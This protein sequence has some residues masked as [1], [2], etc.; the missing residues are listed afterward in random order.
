MADSAADHPNIWSGGSREAVPHFR[1]EVAG[2]GVF[3]HA[4]SCIFD[5]RSWGHAKDLEGGNWRVVHTSS[6]QYLSPCRRSKELDV[7]ELSCTSS[8]LKAFTLALIT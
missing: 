3:T 7:D 4:P 1:V 2:L 5:N 6:P 8:I